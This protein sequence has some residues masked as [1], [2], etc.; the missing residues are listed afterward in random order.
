MKI[1][2]LKPIKKKEDEIKKDDVN[3]SKNPSEK[4]ALENHL[5]KEKDKSIEEL[6]D[7]LLDEKSNT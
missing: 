3:Y 7:D 4:T 2:K 1:S 5:I 6:I